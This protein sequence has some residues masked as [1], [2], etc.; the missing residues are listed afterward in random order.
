MPS[1]LSSSS[2]ESSTADSARADEDA[3]IAAAWSWIS[4]RPTR[5]TSD[6]AVPSKPA[7][8]RLRRKAATLTR[9]LLSPSSRSTSFSGLWS[10]SM[11]PP[12]RL[13]GLRGSLARV[14]S[15]D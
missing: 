1:G 10:S 8:D 2:D 9:R 7:D 12:A 15:Y 11:P 5:S 3:S 13:V 4:S 14:H 6:V